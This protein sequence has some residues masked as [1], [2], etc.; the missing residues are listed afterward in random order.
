MSN[1][2]ESGMVCVRCHVAGRVQGV[3]FRASARYEA[4]RLGIKGYAKNLHDGRVEVVAC[5]SVS[6]VGELR[7]WLRKGPANAEVSG[8]S[9]AVI[10]F[11]DYPQFVVG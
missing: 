6:A 10:D 1:Q 3:F 5:G 9:C 7:E 4:Q 11:H 8:V 2:S